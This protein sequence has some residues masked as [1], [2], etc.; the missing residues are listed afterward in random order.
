M[1]IGTGGVS[2]FALLLLIAVGVRPIVTSS[3]DEKIESVKKLSPLVEGINY[4]THPDP[5]A[6]VYRLTN[7]KG[8]KI[9]V[10]NGGVQSIPSN[11]GSVG[12]KGTI[13]LVG[14]LGGFAADWNPSSLMGLMA[15]S[16][17]LQ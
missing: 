1:N 6:E 12:S 13:S 15:K 14:F 8:A 16:A 2:M 9:V 11:L 10:N 4:R 5:T 3:S 7:G 17:K